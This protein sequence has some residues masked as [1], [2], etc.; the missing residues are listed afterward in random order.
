MPWPKSKRYGSVNNFGFGGT[1]AHV[2]L[3]KAPL[4]AKHDR[5][6]V[7]ANGT[8]I[9][10]GHAA[11]N[12]ISHTN[13]HTLTKSQTLTNGHTLTNGDSSTPSKQHNQRRLFVFS[14][15]DETALKSRLKDLVIYLEQHPPAFQ[16][17][18]LPNLAYTLGQRRSTLSWKVA[19]PASLSHE[20][21]SAISSNALTLRRSASQPNIAFVFTGQGAQWPHMGREL[22]AYPVFASTMEYADL[23]LRN[24]GATFSLIGTYCLE[25]SFQL[26]LVS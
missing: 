15:N 7:L 24:L 22:L 5:N 11:T 16:G 14:A 26:V 21:I 1:N 20:L 6:A 19:V 12:G 3:E 4:P 25:I 13:G 2:I 17:A 8:S 23:C 18:L 10:S 9:T